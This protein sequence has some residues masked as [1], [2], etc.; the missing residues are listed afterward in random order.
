MIW[1][2]NIPWNLPFDASIPRDA[3]LL[4]NKFEKK[5][6]KKF[7]AKESDVAEIIIFFV[8][9]GHLTR[10]GASFMLMVSQSLST[11]LVLSFVHLECR[12]SL[13]GFMY[14]TG[15]DNLTLRHTRTA[16]IQDRRGSLGAGR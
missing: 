9:S 10:A 13:I 3:L 15:L 8:A 5:K 1:K 14:W 16:Q 12:L 4:E 11:S 6:G 2:S 7:C